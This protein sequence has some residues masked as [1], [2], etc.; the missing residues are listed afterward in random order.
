MGQAILDFQLLNYQITHL[1]N[2][3]D[4][5]E[6]KTCCQGLRGGADIYVCG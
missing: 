4:G 6:G 5:A 3:A 1:P 2:L